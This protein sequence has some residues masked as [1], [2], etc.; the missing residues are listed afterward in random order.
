LLNVSGDALAMLPLPIFAADAVRSW[1]AGGEGAA[2][3][4]AATIGGAA[5][6]AWCLLTYGAAVF[7]FAGQDLTSE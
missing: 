6:V 5:L 3:A 2:S 1:I 4:G 7:L